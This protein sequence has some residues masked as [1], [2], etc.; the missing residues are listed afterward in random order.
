MSDLHINI[1]PRFEWGTFLWSYIHTI[2]LLDNSDNM[3]KI[4]QNLDI[5]ITCEMCKDTYRQVLIDHP[6]VAY[7]DSNNIHSIFYW[8]V[9][10]H[11][12]VNRHLGKKEWT[13]EEAL[14]YWGAPREHFIM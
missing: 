10:L 3:L 7:R 12:I 5:F 11:N 1:R 6:P 9:L 8:T 13:N 4:M 2:T 14:E